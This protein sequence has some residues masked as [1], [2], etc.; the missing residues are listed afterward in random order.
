MKINTFVSRALLAS[1]LLITF[2]SN[3]QS[4]RIEDNPKN[5]AK[6][7]SY[8]QGY[9]SAVLKALQMSVNDII[10]VKVMYDNSF[11][12]GCTIV[13]DTPKGPRYCTIPEI[14]SNGKTYLAHTPHATA[15]DKS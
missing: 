12:F 11:H 8:T 13:F 14:V 7:T 4:N 1:T 5:C 9:E 15:C 3:A 6:V 2:N 10:L